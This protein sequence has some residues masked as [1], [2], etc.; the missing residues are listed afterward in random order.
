MALL[1]ATS[2]K[3]RATE[4]RSSVFD[5]RAAVVVENMLNLS[6]AAANRKWIIAG[7]SKLR[8]AS[9]SAGKQRARVAPLWILM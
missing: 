8:A 4:A 7:A 2:V 6:W 9:G 1:M 3:N 5:H